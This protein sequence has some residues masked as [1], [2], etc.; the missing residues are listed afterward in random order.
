MKKLLLVVILFGTQI[1]AHAQD[2]AATIDVNDKK[3]TR[4]ID[5]VVTPDKYTYT[6]AK[7]EIKLLTEKEE[8]K[9]KIHYAKHVMLINTANYPIEDYIFV[10]NRS[11]YLN[12]DLPAYIKLPISLN[13]K[14]LSQEDRKK[15]LPGLDSKKVKRI[16]FLNRTSA[17]NKYHST[18]FGVIEIIQ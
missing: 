9:L 1:I 7:H 5:G 10:Q 16:T 11:K 15:I 8:V 4:I 13:G 18:P 3:Y 6:E 12:T 14:L 2:K 17:Q